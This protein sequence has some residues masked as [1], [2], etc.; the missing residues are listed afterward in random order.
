M[1]SNVIEVVAGIIWNDSGQFLAAQRPEGKNFAGWWEF[2]GGKIEAGESS[3]AALVR[4]LQEELAISATE[5]VYWQQ[6]EHCYQHATVSIDFFHVFQFDRDID[7]QEQQAVRWV[8]PEEA[9]QMQFLPADEEIL[10]LLQKYD[11][12]Q[13]ERVK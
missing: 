9:V 12:P 6:V 11:F 7:P 10:Q 1:A 5:N 3:E 2:P 13:S 4:E 8:H